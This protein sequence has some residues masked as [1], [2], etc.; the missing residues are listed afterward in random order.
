MKLTDK[1]DALMKQHGLNRRQFS[2]LSGIPYMTIV[3]FYEKG[4]DIVKIS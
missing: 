1:L 3:S 2:Q 4:T